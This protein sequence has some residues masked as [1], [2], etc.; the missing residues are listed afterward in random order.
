VRVSSLAALYAQKEEIS[1]G[2][3]RGFYAGMGRDGRFW[4]GMPCR[5]EFA[6]RERGAFDFAHEDSA[7]ARLKPGSPGAALIAGLKRCATQNRLYAA[8]KRRSSTVAFEK[9]SRNAVGLWVMW[10][11]G[12]LRLR[13][14]FIR[15][16]GLLRSGRHLQGRIRAS[17]WRTGSNWRERYRETV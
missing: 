6:Q 16:I 14:R 15:R 1:R 9:R 10:V 13:N 4:A 8:L 7:W 3:S 11:K 12:I 2:D 5:L 17:G